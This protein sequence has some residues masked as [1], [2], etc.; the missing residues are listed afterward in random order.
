MEEAF[1]FLQ[2]TYSISPQDCREWTVLDIGAAPGGWTSF[3]SNQVKKVIAVDPAEM[4]PIVLKNENVIQLK[5]NFEILI[6]QDFDEWV[7][8]FHSTISN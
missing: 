8:Y 3:L 1:Q 2:K 7:I 5:K 6:E 4:D